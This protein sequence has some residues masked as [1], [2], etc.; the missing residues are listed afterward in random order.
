VSR[1]RTG[2]LHGDRMTRNLGSK[3]QHDRNSVSTVRASVLPA[4]APGLWTDC[5]ASPRSPTRCSIAPRARLPVACHLRAISLGKKEQGHYAEL[6]VR[7]GLRFGRKHLSGH[8][9]SAVSVTATAARP[10]FT[11]SGS[12]LP[13]PQV[14]PISP[15]PCLDSTPPEAALPRVPHVVGLIHLPGRVS[16]KKAAPADPA[17]P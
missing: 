10:S 12:A 9:K 2:T 8:G 6:C 16:I 11:S 15:R 1:V 4:V 13:R 7:R 17:R 5:S 14:P 3:R